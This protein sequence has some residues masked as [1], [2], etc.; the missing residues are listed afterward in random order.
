MKFLMPAIRFKIFMTLLLGLIYP[1]TMTGLSQVFFPRQASGDF[2]SRGGQVVGSNLIGQNFEKLE[3]FWGRPS[4]ISYNPLPSGGSNLGQ[5]NPSLKATVDERKIK[6]KAAHPENGEPPQ[7]LVFASGSGLDP[8]ISVEAAKYQLQRVAKARNVDA[9]QIEKLIKQA[10]EERKL[11]F[12]GEPT[13]NVLAL[14]MALDKSQGID[15]KSNDSLL[16]RDK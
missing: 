12:L 16:E 11:G 5:I 3:Y 15:I 8:Q 7:D 1:F 6:L 9:D 2:V 10:T 14:N 4:A 13:V